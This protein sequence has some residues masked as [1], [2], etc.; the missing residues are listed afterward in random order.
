MFIS[1]SWCNNTM[2]NELKK[3]EKRKRLPERRILAKKR[4]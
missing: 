2:K 3:K 4:S 1:L